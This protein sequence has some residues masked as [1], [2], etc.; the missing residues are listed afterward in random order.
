MAAPEL[1]DVFAEEHL[2]K[3]VT[4]WREATKQTRLVFYPTDCLSKPS[5]KYTLFIKLP[6]TSHWAVKWIN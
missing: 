6:T 4:L 1:I 5:R 2:D 3:S